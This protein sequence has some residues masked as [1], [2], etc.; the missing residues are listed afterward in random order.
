MTTAAMFARSSTRS[1]SHVRLAQAVTLSFLYSLPAVWS[2]SSVD[3]VADNDIWWHLAT[4]RWILHHFAIPQTDPFSAFGFGKP[5]MAYSWGFEAPAAWV[6]ENLGLMGLLLLHC[7]LVTAVAV[8][9]HRLLASLLLDFTLAVGLTAAA[10]VAMNA[11]FTPRPWLFTI[12]FFILELHVILGV[13]A[14][15]STRQLLWLPLIFCIW[16]NLHVQVVYGMFLLLLASADSWRNWIRNP[17]DPLQLRS[18]NIWTA[19]TFV[20][21]AATLLNPYFTGI[22]KVAYQL[23]TQPGLVNFITELG[24]LP[25]RSLSNYIL[26]M[27]GISAVALLGHR[28]QARPFSSVLLVWAIVFSF[29]SQRDMWLLAIVGAVTIAECLEAKRNTEAQQTTYQVWSIVIGILFVIAGTCWFTGVSAKKLQAKTST[30][31]PAGAVEF[32]KERGLSGPLFN[33]FNWGGYLIWNLPELP[34][35][36]DGRTNVHGTPRILRSA[37]TWQGRHDWSAD[38]EL[39]QARLVI[40]PVDSPLCS[41]L[42]SDP[43]YHLAYEDS[44]AAVFTRAERPDNPLLSAQ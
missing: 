34:V 41:L 21:I 6:V 27:I 22:Y 16:A 14:G 15:G 32:V 4:G 20:C 28:G 43:R 17:R 36:M 2:V 11:M 23:G 12:L 39:Q 18:R 3:V 37:A 30:M 24:S 9:L 31:F 1:A 29:R 38:L 33:D 8:A 44:L 25:F 7:L 13:R 35:S 5:W 42:R 40:G 19:A 10:V 26:L